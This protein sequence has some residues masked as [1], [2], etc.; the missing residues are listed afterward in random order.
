[1]RSNSKLLRSFIYISAIVFAVAALSCDTGIK[2]GLTFK[3]EVHVSSGLK[4]NECHS[5]GG[6]LPTIEVCKTCHSEAIGNITPEKI[7]SLMKSV[8]NRKGAFGLTFEHPRHSTLECSECHKVAGNTV[9]IPKMN[10]CL[11]MC[12]SEAQ[13]LPLTCNKCHS[14]LSSTGKPNNHRVGWEVKHGSYAYANSTECKVC[15]QEN[16]CFECHRINKPTNHNQSWRLRGH[17]V[18]AQADRERCQSCHTQDFC[19][20]CHL[21]TKPINHTPSWNN[22][23]YQHCRQCHIPVSN[24]NCAVCHVQGAS[25]SSAPAW[26]TNITHVTGASC[27]TCHIGPGQKLEHPDNGDNCEV[28]HAK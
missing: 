11:E 6:V 16:K 10:F 25:H 20:R 12:H 14:E 17:G 7:E 19:T 2:N 22:S 15:H 24:S 9:L 3:H 26:P 13:A 28:C 23:A 18:V 1:M 4:C 5:A 8:S 21:E 27:R